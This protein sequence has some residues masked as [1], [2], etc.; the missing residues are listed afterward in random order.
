MK[1]SPIILDVFRILVPYISLLDLYSDCVSFLNNM[2]SFFFIS[3]RR[4]HYFVIILK[5]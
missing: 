3:T 4:V 1:L 5:R 2:E